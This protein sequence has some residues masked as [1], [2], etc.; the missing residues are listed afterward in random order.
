MAS[1]IGPPLVYRPGGGAR[2]RHA[3]VTKN[4]PQPSGC[5]PPPRTMAQTHLPARSTSGGTCPLVT[6]SPAFE[7]PV[8]QA[9]VLGFPSC[10]LLK[11]SITSGRAMLRAPA[12]LA[13]HGR[14][15][16]WRHAV[17]LLRSVPVQQ[18]PIGGTVALWDS[19]PGTIHVATSC[20]PARPGRRPPVVVRIHAG[21]MWPGQLAVGRGQAPVPAGKESG[22]E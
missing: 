2:A 12:R 10:K 6:I 15:A 5:G 7:K 13:R 3:P 4:G 9:T 19:Q 8:V 18:V 21:I 20:P 1:S 16:V 17:C 11:L 22:L 14:F